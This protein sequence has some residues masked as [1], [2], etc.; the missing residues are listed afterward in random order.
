MT[1][2]CTVDNSQTT[3]LLTH[4]SDGIAH[5]RPMN[6]AI[7]VRL[8]NRTRQ[9]WPSN[10]HAGGPL[11]ASVCGTSEDAIS[12]APGTYNSASDAG[13]TFGSVLDYADFQENGGIIHARNSKYLAIPQTDAAKAAGSPL[14]FGRPL[15]M[16]PTRD[17]TGYVLVDGEEVT[18]TRGKNRGGTRIAP[19]G[20]G[21]RRGIINTGNATIQ[22]VL[23]E[24]AKGE[25]H[26]FMPSGDEVDAAAQEV[27][28][29]YAQ[30]LCDGKTIDI[31]G[32]VV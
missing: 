32:Q 1:W 29:T 13:F 26:H 3:A 7:V 24:I 25:P 16:I 20:S 2:S 21:T 18:I 4:I 8:Q 28:D 12:T 27:S 6:A 31:T 22:F 23:K 17:K 5:P 9:Q 14:K 15:A 30:A 10:L 19:A 11:Q